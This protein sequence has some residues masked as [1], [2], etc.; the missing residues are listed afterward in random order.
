MKIPLMGLEIR[1]I[2]RL[3]SPVQSFLKIEA[4]G[5]ILLLL[6]TVVALVWANSPW[7]ES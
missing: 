1:P 2:D 4:A 6:F 3:L 5:G 7:A